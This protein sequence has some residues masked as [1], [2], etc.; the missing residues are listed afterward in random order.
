MR[1]LSFGSA[2]EPDSVRQA[3]A[4]VNA[5]SIQEGTGGKLENSKPKNADLRGVNNFLANA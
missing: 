1:G 2:I 4:A 5:T 3:R